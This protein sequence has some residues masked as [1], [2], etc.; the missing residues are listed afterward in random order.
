[1]GHRFKIGDL[2]P[3]RAEVCR[4][5]SRPSFSHHPRAPGI[6]WCAMTGN[7]ML[8][9]LEAKPEPEGARILIVTFALPFETLCVGCG[10]VFACGMQFDARKRAAM[11]SKQ[12]GLITW[13]YSVPCETCGASLQFDT[14]RGQERFQPSGAAERVGRRMESRESEN[15]PP[16]SSNK[17][18]RQLMCVEY[19]ADATSSALRERSARASFKL[20]IDLGSAADLEA[21]MR[22]REARYADTAGTADLL[23]TAHKSKWD[24][25]PLRVESCMA[26]G[27]A[28]K[29]RKDDSKCRRSRPLAAPKQ[30]LT[31]QQSRTGRMR[32][33][34]FMLARKA[35]RRLSRGGAL[36]HLRNCLAR[37][38][39]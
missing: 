8:Q 19:V 18:R 11:V 39:E 26:V 24:K 6:S 35:I 28:R 5:S 15:E 20:D 3:F 7:M 14:N 34:N 17:Y 36:S 33:S 4:S 22:R 2:E 31:K 16:P 32:R 12:E 13:R 23:D 21:L 37:K 30:P 29:Q 9:P 10:S 25:T 1:M 27:G 38:T